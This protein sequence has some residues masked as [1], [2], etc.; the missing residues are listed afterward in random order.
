MRC[1]TR[2]EGCELLT[3]VHG[4]ECGSH[5]S[6][7]ML[8]G[9]AFRHGFYWPTA[10]PGVIELV[11]TCQF[12]AKQIHTLVQMLQMFPP[13]WPF[14]VWGLDIL[15]PFSR[16]IGGCRYLYVAIDKFTKWLEATP[17][18]K[19]NKQS[20]VKFIKSIICGFGVPNRII[21]NNGSQFTRS[22]FQ[23]YYEDLGIKICYV[24]IAHPESS[25]QVERA[26]AEI[27]MGLKTRTYDGLKKHGKRWINELSCTLWGNGTSPSRATRET[28]FFM[29]Y[30]AK[31]VLPPE[32][33]M[34][35][36]HV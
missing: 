21:T 16:A 35:S 11:K 36:L 13:T 23:G 3:D 29:V 32:V 2:E 7:H 9:K 14:T 4:G 18:V 28:P 10:L 20:T 30:E 33:T 26:N 24:S 1:I 6:S 27:L 15:G 25:G 19:I 8:V 12:Y 17:M 22:A 34:A 5:A 31:A